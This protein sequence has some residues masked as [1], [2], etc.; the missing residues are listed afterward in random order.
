MIIML[1]ITIVTIIISIIIVINSIIII[2]IT[3]FLT[4]FLTPTSAPY[5]STVRTI[6]TYPYLLARMRAVSPTCI[7]TKHLDDDYDDD[8][9]YKIPYAYMQTLEHQFQHNINFIIIIIIIII[10]SHHYFDSLHYS[11]LQHM[12]RT[13]VAYVQC[14]RNPSHW[15]SRAVAP[16]FY[17]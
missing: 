16:T 17:Y 1:I 2:I 7:Q 5:S 10:I 15:P 12:L 6:S 13:Q 8:D 11:V 14:Q 9:E 3:R 4:L